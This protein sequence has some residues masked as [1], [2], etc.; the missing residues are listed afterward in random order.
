MSVWSFNLDKS[1]QNEK[2]K[3]PYALKDPYG[4]KQDIQD[5]VVKSGQVQGTN[6]VEVLER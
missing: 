1:N 5:I 3:E 4:Y 2:K 6:E